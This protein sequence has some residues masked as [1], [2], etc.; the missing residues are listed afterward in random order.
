M[1][2]WGTQREDGRSGSGNNLTIKLR[3]KV[4]EEDIVK[5]RGRKRSS[6]KDFNTKFKGMD[7]F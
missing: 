1:G 7:K 3:K 2:Q 5:T 6:Q 4:W